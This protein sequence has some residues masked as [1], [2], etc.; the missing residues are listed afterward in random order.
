[1]AL[2]A[3]NVLIK[4]IEANNNTTVGTAK[5]ITWK[6]PLTYNY[7]GG[8][9]WTDGDN[10]YF[11]RGWLAGSSG[12]QLQLD[13][14]TSTWRTKTW[15]GLSESLFFGDGV[16]TDG[17]NIYYIDPN[18]KKRYQLDRSTSTWN[19]KTWNGFTELSSAAFVWTE[20]ANIY[21][22]SGTDQYQLDTNTSTWNPKTWNGL[23][24]FYGSNIWTD[25]TNIYYSSGAKQ[26]QLDKSTSTWSPKTWN[27]H[28]TFIGQRVWTDGENIYWSE[29]TSQY[30]LDKSTS[31]WSPKTW[32]GLTD[33]YSSDTWTDGVNT[34]CST[35]TGQY[36]LDKST[37]T[38]NPKTWYEPFDLELGENVWTDGTNIFYSDDQKQYQL[39]TSSLIWHPK[40][41]NGVTEIYGDKVWTDGTNIY[42]SATFATA[43][44]EGQQSFQYQ[45]NKSTSTWSEKTW[46]GLTDFDGSDVWTDGT[47]IFYSQ[48]QKQYQLDKS[49]STWVSQTWHGLSDFSGWNVWTDGTN[50]YYSHTDA[51]YQLYPPTPIHYCYKG[52]TC[53]WVKPYTITVKVTGA[54]NANIKVII[55]RSSN[56]KGQEPSAVYDSSGGESSYV[57]NVAST[58]ADGQQIVG[59]YGDTLYVKAQSYSSGSDRYSINGQ[60]YTVTGDGQLSVN[61]SHSA[62]CSSCNT[63]ALKNICNT[64][65]NTNLKHI[66]I[67]SGT[68]KT[69]GIC[70]F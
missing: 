39:D 47:K 37:S 45:L 8:Y 27:G 62:T 48:D 53:Q 5:P 35:G 24:N 4:S 56:A 69:S 58:A 43:G 60:S 23:T 30:K 13:K 21:Y 20:G 64:R 16:W 22:S 44:G 54:P 61:V 26:Y 59:Y 9:I 55:Y 7:Q 12:R 36:Q 25:G 10:I 19:P 28:S 67:C 50:M 33:F 1:M 17:T 63:S 29:S 31:T 57:I 14:V 40:T 46:S 70:E 3:N 49:T 15:N 38:W 51:Q 42:Y 6:T 52:D 2:K 68:S 11:S 18:Q 65:C 32:N 34:Y 41:W 66:G